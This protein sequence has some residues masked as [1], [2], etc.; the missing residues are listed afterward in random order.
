[1]VCAVTPRMVN[2]ALGNGTV[3]P[4]IAWAVAPLKSLLLRGVGK[5]AETVVWAATSREAEELAAGR[6][7]KVGVGGRRGGGG[8][9]RGGGGGGGGEGGWTFFGDMKEVPFSDAAKDE[10]LAAKV[11]AASEEASGLEECERCA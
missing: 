6:G 10:A 8:G 4:W 3:N 11:W 7:G 2:T 9:G 1:M 5:G